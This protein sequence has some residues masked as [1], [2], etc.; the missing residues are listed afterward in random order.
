M[1]VAAAIVLPATDTYR[2]TGIERTEGPD[3]QD[4]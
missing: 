4:N 1:V 3:H 2:A